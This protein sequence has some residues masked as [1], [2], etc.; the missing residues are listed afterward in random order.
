MKIAAAVLGFLLSITMLGG[1]AVADPD[2][3]GQSVID[4]SREGVTPKSKC[5][6]GYELRNLKRGTPRAEAERF[7]DG[8]G[9]SDGPLIR[10]YRSCAYSWRFANVSVSYY[11]GRVF[12]VIRIR[13]KNG[14]LVI[15]PRDS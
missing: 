1:P 6:S 12:D 13:S 11:K 15:P 10:A 7:L 9:R 3:P 5:V 14:T 4:G 8:R 2:L